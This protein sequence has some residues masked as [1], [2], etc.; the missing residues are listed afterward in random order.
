MADYRQRRNPE[1][2]ARARNRRLATQ[3]ALLQLRD[4][5]RAEYV[6]LLDAE[7]LRRADE[8]R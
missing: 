1:K 6:K 4:R 2:A 8:R 3:R 5:H 7:L